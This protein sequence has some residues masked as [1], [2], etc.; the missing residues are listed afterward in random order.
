MVGVSVNYYKEFFLN[1]T[2]KS[3][4]ENR[5]EIKSNN[6]CAMYVRRGEKSLI[7]SAVLHEISQCCRVT[8]FNLDL[9]LSI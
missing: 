3:P 5:V 7:N 6:N 1:K 8:V 9:I 4:A 2:R